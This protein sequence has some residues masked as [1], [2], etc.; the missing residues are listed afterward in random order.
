[1]DLPHAACCGAVRHA[2]AVLAAAAA[3]LAQAAPPP[4]SAEQIVEKNVAARGGLAAWRAVKA[5]RMSGLMD[6]GKTRP[7][8]MT[9]AI[10]EAR[11]RNVPRRNLAESGV[12]QPLTPAQVEE[13]KKRGEQIKTIQLPFSMD[14]QRPRMQRLEIEV[15]KQTAVQVY[16]GQQGWKLRPYLGRREVE[17]YTTAELKQAA[18]QQ[19]LDGYLIDHAAKGTR[20]AYAGADRFEGRDV[21]K[22]NLT[23]KD[24]QT[25]QVWIDA[26][27]FLEVKIDEPR[28]LHGRNKTVS[29][30]LR[31]YRTV[32][33]VKVPFLIETQVSG[34]TDSN[35]IVVDKVVVNPPLEAG[36]FA[37][38][39]V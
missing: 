12:I 10:D 22:L 13:L 36:R 18:D 32:D 37:K 17:P 11:M 15:N 4:M 24:G 31:D 21:Y 6:A 9:K 5:M 28:K 33:G 7:E 2:V 30:V 29:T 23:L 35:K 1:M 38:P 19:D 26:Q 25:R 39:A 20:I 3:L 34:T 16:D 27:T 14:L 8:S